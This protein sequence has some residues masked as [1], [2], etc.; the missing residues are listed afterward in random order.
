LLLLA[1][2]VRA[3]PAAAQSELTL[4]C[5]YTGQEEAELRAALVRFESSHATRVRLLTI[6]FGA[7]AAKL[8]AAIPTGNGPDLFIDAHERLPTYVARQLIE[9]WAQP[10]TDAFPPKTAEA[11]RF[12]GR[13]YGLPLSVKSLALY[14]NEALVGTEPVTSM[15]QLE[16]L[17]TRLPPGV[18]PLAFEAENPYYAVAALHAFGGNLLEA[19]G[20][21]GF[22]GPAAEKAL[23]ALLRWTRDGVVPEAPTGDLVKRLFASGQAATAISGPWLAADLPRELKFRI[24]PL[25]RLTDAPGSERLESYSTIEGVF[26]AAHAAHPEQARELARFLAQRAAP[27]RAAVLGRPMPVHP[28]MR[29]VWEPAT[30]ALE[31]AL[32]GGLEPKM[33]LER[34][35]T[36]FRRT[37]RAAPSPSRPAGGVL[38]LGALSLA[39]AWSGVRRARDAAFRRRAARSRRAYAY[40]AQSLAAVGLL[41]VLPLLVGFATS[42]FSGSGADLHYVGLG[43]YIDILRGSGGA[44]FESGSFWF[45]LVIT[46][47]WTLANLVLH[48][49]LGAALALLLARPTLRASKFYRVLL[50]LPWAVPSYVTALTWKGMFHRQFGAINALLSSCGFAPLD[51]FSSFL[52]AFSANLLTNVWLGFPFMMVVTLGALTSISKDVY[53]AAAVDGA[54]GWQRLRHVTLPLIRPTLVPAMLLGAAWTF[55]LF[56]V[57]FFVSGGEPGG[58]TEILVSEAYRW[59]FTRSGQ[60]G[61]AAAYAVLIFGVL[62]LLTRS[63]GQRRWEAASA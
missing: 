62:L 2:V 28:L 61:Y 15:T 38:V 48:V 5:A 57:V 23:G 20:R 25:P 50:I 22:V 35:A 56:N 52:T 34:G 7:Y 45:V 39:G 11:L 58:T 53:E 19:D 32:R 44:L 21:Y 63:I 1:L 14:V 30:R 54:S 10:L 13:Q 41:V 4:W 6:P 47:L 16:R 40:L 9:P 31:S 8:E 55:N 36:Q 26:V 18:Y 27:Q 33:A 37:T 3:T 59:A 46:L 60:Y 43:N 51:W 17:R 42:F 49:L 12:E 29:A 24:E